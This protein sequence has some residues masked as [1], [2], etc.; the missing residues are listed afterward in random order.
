MRFELLAEYDWKI[1][2]NDSWLHL[3][4]SGGSATGADK[5]LF[6]LEVDDNNSG[7][8]RTG[9]IIFEMNYNGYTEKKDIQV[10][11]ASR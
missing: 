10:S 1:S 6:M 11:Q 8:M 3:S 4:S 7:K 9:H 5:Y 2:T